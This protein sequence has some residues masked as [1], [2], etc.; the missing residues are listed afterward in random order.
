MCIVMVNIPAYYVYGI[1]FF[2]ILLNHDKK[3]YVRILYRGV[4]VGVGFL[5]VSRNPLGIY[6]S[7][8]YSTLKLGQ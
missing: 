7:I 5:G 1:H 4:Y 3:L 2:L 8:G 6:H